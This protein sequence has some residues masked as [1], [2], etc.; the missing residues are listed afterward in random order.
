[1][2]YFK[3]IA[4]KAR[5][6]GLLSIDKEISE[7]D[8]LDPFI[9]KGLELMVDDGQMIKLSGQGEV[10]EKGAPRGDLYIVVNVKS[11]PLFTR[12]GN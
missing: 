6:E 5:K 10:G 9:R 2:I 11:H 4:T 1:I 12:D 7:N 8:E 3:E